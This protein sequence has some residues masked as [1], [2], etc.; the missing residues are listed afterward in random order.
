MTSGCWT[1]GRPGA[2]TQRRGP[3]RRPGRARPGIPRRGR[4]HDRAAGSRPHGRRR[5]SQPTGATAAPEPVLAGPGGRA[6]GRPPAR[7]RRPDG[8]ARATA[9]ERASAMAARFAGGWPFGRIIGVGVL[10]V[11]LFSLLA[12]GVGGTALADLTT[13]RNHV[14]NTLDPAAFHASQ[15]EVELLNQETGVRGYALSAQPAFLEPYHDGPG[16][17]APAGQP[18][19]GH[20]WPGV[21][22]A[23]AQLNQVLQRVGQLAGPR[24]P[25]PRSTRCVRPGQPWQPHG[26]PGQGGLRPDPGRAGRAPGR[27]RHAAAAGRR[28]AARL[29]LGAGGDPHRDRGRAAAHRAGARVRPVA[30]GDPAAVPAGRRRP[31]GGRA[32]TS[33]IRWNPAARPRCAPWGW[34]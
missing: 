34:T 1:A 25:C 14:V 8:A 18:C 10:I 27:P 33:S 7:G 3:G 29:G 31:P 12:I 26:R 19:C 15:L 9:S 32:A 13:A 5:A 20:C 28:H 23:T 16:R 24:T 4:Q 17:A 11:A 2:R 30:V 22:G 6:A 21:P